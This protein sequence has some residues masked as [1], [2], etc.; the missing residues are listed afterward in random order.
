MARGSSWVVAVIAAAAA[1]AVL[2]MSS[3]WREEWRDVDLIESH[4]WQADV[5]LIAASNS[6]AFSKSS[7]ELYR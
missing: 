7:C 1:A 5:I 3:L 6:S 4:E 2:P